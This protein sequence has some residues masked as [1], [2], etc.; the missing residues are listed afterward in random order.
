MKT[1]VRELADGRWVC[2]VK[3]WWHGWHGAIIET[4]Y[5]TLVALHQEKQLRVVRAFA[6][7]SGHYSI[8][9]RSKAEALRVKS[10]AD[11]LFG[12]GATEQAKES[13]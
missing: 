5:S 1:R 8:C 9:I 7:G 2:E 6:P 11:A 4:P 12:V 3:R 10:E 13:T